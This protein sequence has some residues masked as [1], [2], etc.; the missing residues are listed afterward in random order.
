VNSFQSFK[1]YHVPVKKKKKEKKKLA[2]L[3]LRDTDWPLPAH[4]VQA[5]HPG[6]LDLQADPVRASLVETQQTACTRQEV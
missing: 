1:I 4:C 5:G 2:P 6:V 3:E